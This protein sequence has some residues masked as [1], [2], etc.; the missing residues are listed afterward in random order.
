VAPPSPDRILPAIAL[1][2]TS[3][4]LF[5]CMNTLIKLAE[6]HGASLGEILFFRQFGA[7]LLL[8]VVLAAGPGL[9]SVA[10]RRLR[11]HLLRAAMGLTAMAL[12]F[13][14]ILALPLAESTTIGFTMPIFA[15]VLGAVIL[16]EPTGWHRWLAVI[17]GFAGVLI[18][19]QPGAGHFPLWGAATGLAAAAM[20]ASVSILLRQIAK[21][22]A[23]TT[24][25]FW[26]SALSLIPL[27]LIYA[28]VW[29]SHPALTWVLLLG[30]G[31]IGGI[32]QLAM[33]SALRFGPVSVVVPMDYS[34]LLWATA[35]GWLVFG[36]LPGTWT[37]IG[38]PIIVASGLYI[39]WREHVRRRIETGQAIADA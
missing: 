14:T 25:V 32:A 31:L 16:R 20:T 13:A 18:V 27:G 7:T 23:T 10:T 24:T 6:A 4:F 1:R 33:T 38:A 2:L 9:A 22:E 17:A 19:A 5:A 30:I 34:S 15:T 36:V 12:T 8:I 21:T 39:V 35:F 29:Q 26:F 3:V 37:G 11:A 28:F